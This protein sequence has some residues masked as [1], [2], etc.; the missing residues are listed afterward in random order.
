MR[1]S[2][3]RNEK[4]WCLAPHRQSSVLLTTP[5]G[6]HDSKGWRTF[7][8][9]LT[10]CVLPPIV[11]T[12]NSQPRA[13]SGVFLSAF[14]SG[15]RPVMFTFTLVSRRCVPCV[16]HSTFRWGEFKVTYDF[17][18]GQLRVEG[19]RATENTFEE[20]LSCLDSTL[21]F[22]GLVSTQVRKSSTHS[23]R[24]A[25]IVAGAGNSVSA[26]PRRFV[27]LQVELEVPCVTRDCWGS[28]TTSPS[29]SCLKIQRIYS[30]ER[31]FDSFDPPP[32]GAPTHF[33]HTPMILCPICNAGIR[34][35]A[36]SDENTCI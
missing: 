36:N 4:M 27:T 13:S 23:N 32:S 18:G 16:L 31:I 25:N 9:G 22:F 34:L 11:C 8:H 2:T 33:K 24:S 30:F 19:P 15:R 6:S 7:R 35:F 26:R 1:P 10:R 12:K 29:A 5:S 14:Q 3:K 20:L 28:R 21:S 17:D